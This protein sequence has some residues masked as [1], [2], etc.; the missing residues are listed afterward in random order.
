MPRTPCATQRLD[1]R[2]RRRRRGWSTIST[3]GQRAGSR[4]CGSA[5]RRAPRPR[6]HGRKRRSAPSS[7]QRERPGVAATRTRR[8]GTDAPC[9]RR[10]PRAPRR[11][12]PRPRRC[13]PG[14]ARDAPSRRRRFCGPS[15]CSDGGRPHRRRSSTSGLAGASTRCRNYAVSS[16]VSVPCVTT[17]PATSARA[18]WC[19]HALRERAA[20]SRGPC[21]CCRAARPARTRSARRASAG[22]AAT[23][24]A[25]ADLRR[26]CSRRCRP[27][28]G[29]CRRSCRRCR[30]RRRS[31]PLCIFVEAG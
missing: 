5:A 10:A 28:R 2:G 9:A 4:R 23:S 17:T 22:T 27:R 29:A 1:D 30:G 31:M 12:A 26:R 19:A 16:S 11:P 20:R 24:C 25:D 15:A 21:P 13:A 8:A 7:M 14:V 3:R 18:R 6:G